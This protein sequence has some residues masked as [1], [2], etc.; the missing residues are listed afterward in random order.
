MDYLDITTNAQDDIKLVV[1]WIPN[2]ADM[3]TTPNPTPANFTLLVDGVPRAIA[4]T[5]FVTG[6][7]MEVTAVGAPATTGFKVTQDLYDANVRNT[8]NVKAIPGQSVDI[9]IP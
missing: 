6:L 5:Q 3:E 4:A 9:L 7:I 2:N 1:A 8:D